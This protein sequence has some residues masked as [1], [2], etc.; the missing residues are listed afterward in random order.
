MIHSALLFTVAYSY[1]YSLGD[2]ALMEIYTDSYAYKL[3][4]PAR[5]PTQPGLQLSV[6]RTSYAAG[7]TSLPLG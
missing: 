5:A 7:R 1:P 6:A 4:S 3:R 2:A